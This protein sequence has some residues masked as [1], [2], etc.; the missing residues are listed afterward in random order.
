MLK[1]VVLLIGLMVFGLVLAACSS[2]DA[3]PA[4][5]PTPQPTATPI[6]LSVVTTT[7]Q[8]ALGT[9]LQDAIKQSVQEAIS[10]LDIPTGPEPI[11]QA[12]L[13]RMVKAAVEAAASEGATPEEIRNM[14]TAAV[15]SATAGAA[16]RDDVESLVTEAVTTAVASQP[17]AP[18]V[19]DIKKVVADALAALPTV[20]PVPTATAAPTATPV[21]TATA[22]PT[23]APIVIRPGK[24]GGVPPGST[25]VDIFHFGIHECTGFDNTCLAHPAPN[26]NGLIEYNPETDDI[27]D[28]RCDLCTSWELDDSGTVYTFHLDP[29]ARWTNGQPVTATDAV[30]SLDRMVDPDKL[31]VKTRAIAP[32]YESSQVVDT[33]TVEVKTKFPAPA[34]F[35]FLAAEY[36]KILSK[37]HVQSVPDED[38][39]AF[40]HIMGSGPF[41]LINVEKGIKLEYVRNQDYF[42]EGLPYWDGMTL[43]I[44]TDM[45]RLAAAF[46]TQQ[47]LYTV[48]SNSGLSNKTALELA[49]DLVGKARMIFV[50]PIA[51][52]GIFMNVERPPFDDARVRHALWLTMHRQPYVQTFS[53]GVDLLGGPFPPNAWYGIP[54][55]ELKQMPGFRETADGGKSPDD[56]ALAKALLAEAGVEEGFQ[57]TIAYPIIFEHPG[58]ATIFQDQL[59][60]FLNWD[61]EIDGLEVLTWIGVRDA[62]QWELTSFGY[63][64]LAHDP[65]DIIG[66]VF[67]KDGGSNYSKW[68]DPRIEDIYL[69]Q[70][71]ELDRTKR[72]ALIDEATRIFMEEDSPVIFTYHTVRGHYSAY[73]V[74]NHHRVGTLSDALKAEHFWCDPAC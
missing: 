64:I 61:V 4:P 8:S 72:K 66:G 18:D 33:N 67:V 51:P 17:E 70:A 65:H 40:E 2:D 5:Q 16:T 55:D 28:I 68:S 27:S 54:E 14:V 47:V 29:N 39:K 48:H 10:G 56:I 46:R 52:L 15:E 59:N 36:M 9:A 32:F 50:G 44:I 26:Y 57:T 22:A 3:A 41:K 53:N 42:K 38:M 13:Q 25:N 63:G 71:K 7:L 23:Q 34:F 73:Q 21:P 24:R 30:F 20:T 31:H 45:D 19:E 35:P 6:D 69:K 1:P 12:D 11:N 60:T 74:K 49:K 43:F 37:D 62:L 58:I